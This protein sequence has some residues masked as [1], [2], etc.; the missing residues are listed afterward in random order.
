MNVLNNQ[1]TSPEQRLST[2]FRLINEENADFRANTRD[3]KHFAWKSLVTID[4]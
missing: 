3:L 2:I 1:S 4:I